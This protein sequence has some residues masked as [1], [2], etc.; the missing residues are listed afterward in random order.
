MGSVGIIVNP[1]AGKDVRRLRAAVGH[2]S[3]SAK[4]GTIR[5]VAVAA[6]EAGAERVYAARD[7]G[8]LAER[9]V[10]E[11]AGTELIDGPDTGSALDT[12]R[13]AGQMAELGACPVVILGG[14]GTC[15]DAALGWPDM[16]MIPISTGTNNVFPTIVDGSSA[17]TAAGLIARGAL[18]LAEVSTPAKT[19]TVEVTAGHGTNSTAGHGTRTDVALV[20]V[21]LIDTPRVGARAVLDVGRVRA[22]VATIASPTSTGLSS[23]AGRVHPLGR[24]EPGAIAVT[25]HPAPTA[26]RRVRAP[27]VPGSFDTV[28]ISSVEVVPDRASVTLAGPGVLAFDG[29]RELPVAGDETVRVTVRAD[30]PRVVDVPRAL[31]LAAERRL[32]DVWET[33][34]AR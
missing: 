8:R 31:Q 6:L 9:A 28:G 25:C 14:D 18:T 29:E 11:L 23:I 4:I 1:W 15:R 24:D 16:P 7:T 13:A 30:G 19:L 26:P 5:R 10:A 27:I 22:V 33:D 34:D 3:D 20:D 21:A 2:T 17:G 32:F 12:R